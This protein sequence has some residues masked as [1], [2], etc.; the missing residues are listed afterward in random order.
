MS[1]EVDLGALLRGLQ[2]VLHE[3][4]FVFVTRSSEGIPPLG[5]TPRMVFQETKGTTFILRR[6]EAEAL[7]WAFE[8]PCRMI[9]L[10]VHS[11]L[12]AVGFIAHIA[13]ELAK[14]DMGVNPVSGFFHDHLFVP[15]DRA[16]DAMDILNRIA[17]G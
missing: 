7:G 13:T 11:A 2:A 15:E 10:N 16:A 3:D 4:T 14:A 9:T 5:I 12:E 8:F 1:G 17:K 6:A